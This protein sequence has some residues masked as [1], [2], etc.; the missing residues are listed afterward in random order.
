MKPEIVQYCVRDVTLL[1]HLWNA[2]SAKLRPRD[3]AFW[4]SRVR[5]ATMVRI[6]LSQSKGYDG[7]SKAMTRAPWNAEQIQQAM[8]DW[9]DDALDMAMEGMDLNDDGEWV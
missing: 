4:R 8:D 2:Y 3:Q 7:Y 5:T 9:N 1:P 6:E